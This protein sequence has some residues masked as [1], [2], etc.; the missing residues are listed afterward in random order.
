VLGHRTLGEAAELAAMN[1]W[2][3]RDLLVER[4]VQLRTGPRDMD[5]AVAEVEVALGSREDA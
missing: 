5:E 4:G 2:E 1:R 3:F